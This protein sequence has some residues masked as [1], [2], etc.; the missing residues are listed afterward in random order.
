MIEW[1]AV[2]NSVSNLLSEHA[3]VA[4]W[5]HRALLFVEQ[6]WLNQHPKIAEQ[7]K[8]MLMAHWGAA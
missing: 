5:N 7:N 8:E 3:A 2:W 4:G 6:E 1:C